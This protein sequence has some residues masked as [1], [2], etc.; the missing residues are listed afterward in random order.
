MKHSPVR[1]LSMMLALLFAF[2]DVGWPLRA[3]AVQPAWGRGARIGIDGTRQRAMLPAIDLFGSERAVQIASGYQRTCALT[4]T[5]GVKCWGDN[6][7]GQLGDGTTQQR[8][9]P[10]DVTGLTSGVRA[11]TTGGFHTCAVTSTGGVKCWGA[12]D[13]GQLGDGTTTQRLTPVDVVGLGD[14]IKAIAAGGGYTCALTE[15]GGVKCWGNNGAGQLGDGTQVDRLTPVDVIGLTGGVQVLSASLYYH[16]CVVTANGGAKCWGNNYR[17]QLG[18]GTTTRRLTPV[19]V[20]GLQ[21][22]VRV[23]SAGSEHTCAVMQTGAAQCWG[24]DPYGQLGIG[25]WQY[26]YPAA[27]VDVV[28]L[29]SGVATISAGGYHTCATLENGGAKCWGNNESGQLGD[30]TASDQRTPVDAVELSGMVR[31]ISTGFE[32]TCAVTDTGGVKCWGDNSSGQLGDGT[33]TMRLMPVDALLFD[34][35]GVSEIPQPE[36]RALVAL[37]DSTAIP[38]WNWTDSTG[39]LRT[40]TPCSWHGVTCAAGH[41]SGLDL[42]SNNLGGPLPAELGNLVALQTLNLNGNDLCCQLPPE[43]GRLNA[44]ETLNLSDN[45]FEGLLPPE[46][47][48]LTALQSLDLWYNLL[49]GPLPA[50]WGGLTALRSLNL[51]DGGSIGGRLPPELG[52]LTALEY[53]ELSHNGFSGAIPPEWGHLTALWYLG[54]DDNQLSGALPPELGNLTA[55]LWLSAYRNALS[56]VLPPQLGQLAALQLLDLRGNALSGPLPA[57]LGDLSALRGLYLSYNQLSG[58]IPPG[59]A[60][61]PVL[62]SLDLSYNQLS[63]PIPSALG[64]LSALTNLYLNDNHLSG[65]IPPELGDLAALQ[66]HVLSSPWLSVWPATAPV[67]QFPWRYTEPFSPDLMPRRG[68]PDS[69]AVVTTTTPSTVLSPPPQ[70]PCCGYLHLSSNQLSGPIPAE[71]AQL[72]GLRSLDLAGNQLSGPI[73]PGVVGLGDY[74]ENLGHNRLDAVAYPG[75]ASTQ[76]VLPADVQVASAWNSVT[77]TWTPIAYTG[78]GGYYEIS[79]SRWPEGSFQVHGQTADKTV[80]SYTVTGLFPGRT[81]YFRVR[82]F[83]PAH[84]F[85]ATDDWGRWRGYTQQSNLWSDYS[86]LVSAGGGT[87]TPTATATPTPTVTSSATP[88][89]TSTATTTPTATATPTTTPDA[90]PTWT[91]TATVKPT[92]TPTAT[93]TATP[94]ATPTPTVTSSATV[95]ATSTPTVTPTDTPTA[96][97]T[98]T[99]TPT[100]TRTPAATPYRRWLPLIWR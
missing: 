85:G 75:I 10:V 79:Y 27:P 34:C 4:V 71:L 43:L 68:L 46:W 57:A 89:A 63:G 55:L 53:L 99:A 62:N 67:G 13:F 23:I 51:Y 44:L 74:W 56:G 92:G 84:A 83:T 30:G 29:Q 40:A 66:G 80:A 18:D 64:K 47:G 16:T 7:H 58:P 100:P 48:K 5:G 78:D 15:N 61:L 21:S 1:L 88:T 33:T 77:L 97:W 6:S 54:L 14:R 50:E 2:V 8:L 12:N 38:G 87:S 96:T 59:L 76:T 32:H 65:P 90:T 24:A 37:F 9:R 95:T 94:T 86:A 36:C 52:N 19:D 41:V 42:H 31:S 93:A 11:L 35:A 26:P 3:N 98:P 49:S 69:R 28:G 17:G 82:T 39:W 91:N 73:P 45:N 72:T 81:Y 20:V 60:K 22:G 25:P 70:P